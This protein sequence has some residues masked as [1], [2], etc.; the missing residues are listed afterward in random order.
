MKLILTGL[1]CMSLYL[2]GCV[3]AKSHSGADTEA[4][5]RIQQRSSQE[6]AGTDTTKLEIEK[7]IIEDLDSQGNVVKRITTGGGRAET[8]SQY[9]QQSDAK[10]LAEASARASA[11]AMS[12]AK[13]DIMP[14]VYLGL[15]ALALLIIFSVG[16]RTVLPLLKLI[17]KP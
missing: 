3:S 2:L 13:A 7:T 16:S 6:M 1:F 5:S 4:M 11:E 8:G 9:N 15:I 12:K 17:K 10:I 14:L